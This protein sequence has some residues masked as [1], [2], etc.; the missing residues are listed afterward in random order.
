MIHYEINVSDVI[1]NAK[2]NA[3]YEKKTTFEVVCQVKC[4]EISF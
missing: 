4:H 3:M 1:N 2:T